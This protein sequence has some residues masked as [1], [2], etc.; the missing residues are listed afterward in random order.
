MRTL[1]AGSFD[2][3]T[4]GHEWIIN[5]APGELIVAVADNPFKQYKFTLQQRM[6]FIIRSV[7]DESVQVVVIGNEYLIDFASRNDV[8][9]IIRGLRSSEDYVYE[10][11]YAMINRE[12]DVAGPRHLFLMP[13]PELESVSSS[14]VKALVGPEGWEK[15]VAK[16]VSPCVLE[17][18]K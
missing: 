4:K 7:A 9:Y 16:Y 5:N 14:M 15:V 6:D 8:D 1:Y 2:P 13:P 17:A 10:R 18:L 12:I 11:N 3:I